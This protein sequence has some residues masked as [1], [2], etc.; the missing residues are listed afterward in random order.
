MLRQPIMRSYILAL[1]LI[2]LV[3]VLLASWF[4][5]YLARG[6]TVPIK[7]LAEG[8]QAIAHGD[9]DYEIPSVGDDEIGQL[10]DSFNRMT[11]DL[12]ASRAE[13]ERRRAYTE[14]L[15]RNVCA[16]VVGLDPAGRRYR[17]QSVRGTD[18]RA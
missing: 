7:L 9:L 4:G 11:A 17:D 2:G 15:V 10:V 14:T 1:V 16:G 8:T 12:R 3:V 13:L 5:M 18:A 6:I